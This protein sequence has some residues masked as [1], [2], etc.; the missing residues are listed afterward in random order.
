MDCV[1]SMHRACLQSFPVCATARER[2]MVMV[3]FFAGNTHIPSLVIG[4]RAAEIILEE[5]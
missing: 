1:W 5:K 3:F 2:I 4:S